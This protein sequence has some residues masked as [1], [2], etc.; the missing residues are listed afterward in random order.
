M[1][2][3]PTLFAGKRAEF[4]RRLKDAQSAMAA[5]QEVV[6]AIAAMQTTVTRTKQACESTWF[7][8][9]TTEKQEM[10]AKLLDKPAALLAFLDARNAA[11]AAESSC[12][13]ALEEQGTFL[14]SLMARM[15]EP[16]RAADIE[17]ESREI[18]LRVVEGIQG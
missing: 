17:R 15:A 1:C 14:S 10:L 11:T 9:L 2:E 4:K 5:N 12:T 3:E 6:R 18:P 13:R 7:R 8:E 16:K